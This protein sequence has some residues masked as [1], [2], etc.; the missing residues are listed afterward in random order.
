MSKRTL[1]I[2][3]S[4]KPHRYSYKAM[5]ALRKGGHE[6]VLIGAKESEVLGLKI[7]TSPV[8]LCE[9]DTVTLYVNSKRQRDWYD[10]VIKLNPKRVIFNPGTENENFSHRL[11]GNNIEATNAC[12]LVMLSVGNY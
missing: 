8:E 1:I 6:V 11:I 7:H 9:I 10:Y 5:E 12:T 4:I 2:G 3:A